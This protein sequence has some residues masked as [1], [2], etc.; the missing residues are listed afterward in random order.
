MLQLLLK[1]NRGFTLLYALLLTAIVLLITLSISNILYRQI[2]T[3]SISVQGETSA[4]AAQTGVQCALYWNDYLSNYGYADAPDGG[5]IGP[6][7]TDLPTGTSIA[8]AGQQI[9]VTTNSGHTTFTVFDVNNVGPSGA[10]V[11][12][13]VSYP[14]GLTLAYTATGI[15]PGNNPC[16]VTSARQTV[17][18]LQSI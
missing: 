11:N 5:G 10:C 3:A 13:D 8:C 2:I 17:R 1:V 14:D 16:T 18:K 4:L 12:V 15:N 9:G 7:I 6:K